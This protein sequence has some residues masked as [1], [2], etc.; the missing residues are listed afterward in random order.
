M[1]TKENC[2]HIC[3][4]IAF[5]RFDGPVIF[6]LLV[7]LLAVAFFHI[8]KKCNVIIKREMSSIFNRKTKNLWYQGAFIH[9]DIKDPVGVLDPP[10]WY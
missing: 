8:F 7:N 4:T 9:P 6:W 3:N 2:Q 1:D 5:A 10:T